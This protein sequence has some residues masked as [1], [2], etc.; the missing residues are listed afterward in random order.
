MDYT[1][2]AAARKA[3]PL[4]MDEG[5]R[6]IKQL[7]ARPPGCRISPY[8]LT[9]TTGHLLLRA[10]LPPQQT[11]SDDT[12]HNHLLSHE[13]GIHEEECRNIS[14]FG[15]VFR[16]ACHSRL[17]S[18]VCATTAS[19]EGPRRCTYLCFLIACLGLYNCE[20]EC[21]FVSSAVFP[22]VCIT[23]LALEFCPNL[24]LAHLVLH[25][26]H[27]HRR[28]DQRRML[29]IGAVGCRRIL[30]NCVFTIG[31]NSFS[32]IPNQRGILSFSSGMTEI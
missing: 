28:S 7:W 1:T 14:G 29:Y 3:H 21:L 30:E 8:M 27:P 15:T 20:M 12:S 16:I 11:I 26:S 4:L 5:G 6:W 25:D 13:S 31:F 22:F 10:K 32:K 9:S 24:R 17:Y 2:R 19:P 23:F 18:L